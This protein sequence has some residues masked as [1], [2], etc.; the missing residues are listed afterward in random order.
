VAKAKAPP[1]IEQLGAGSGC[2][3]SVSGRA[4]P[5]L[6]GVDGIGVPAG[7]CTGPGR[8]RHPAHHGRVL[9]HSGYYYLKKNKNIISDA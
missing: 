7:G 9:L 8:H 4:H 1:V 2:A 5:S 6:P 3:S